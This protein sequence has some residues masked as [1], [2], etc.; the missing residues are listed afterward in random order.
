MYK[1]I[2]MHINDESRV[3]RLV[4][5]GADL[6]QRFQAHLTALCVLP[7]ISKPPIPLL[8]AKS[9]ILCRLSRGSRACPSGVRNCSQGAA[10]RAGMPARSSA[11]A[12]LAKTCSSTPEPVISSS[13]RSAI[14]TGTMRTCSTFRRKWLSRPAGLSDLLITGCYGHAV[15]RIYP[16]RRNATFPALHEGP[17][18]DVASN[19]KSRLPGGCTA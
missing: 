17:G 11:G 18:P 9:F 10:G 4:G 5:V 14:T 8:F 16:R 15:A 3:G 1:T 2:L 19:P 6:A 7:H 13:Y 12:K